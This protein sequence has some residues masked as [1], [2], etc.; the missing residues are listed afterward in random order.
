MRGKDKTGELHGSTLQEIQKEG[1]ADVVQR[2][3]PETDIIA[4][5]VQ[6]DKI[7]DSLQKAG[8][9]SS[10]REEVLRNI[11]TS[12]TGREMFNKD[13]Y[14]RGNTFQ[15]SYGKTEAYNDEVTKEVNIKYNKVMRPMYRKNL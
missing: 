2:Q 9:V 5:K 12:K 6:L 10:S 4:D 11:E 7:G 8:G 13:L 1:L 15:N 3:I 14:I